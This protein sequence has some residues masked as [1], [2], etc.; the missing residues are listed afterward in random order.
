MIACSAI[1]DVPRELVWFLSRLLLAERGRW[2][3]A[4]VFPAGGDR[5]ALVREDREVAALIYQVVG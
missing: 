4:D 1:L 5:A 3:G 2:T